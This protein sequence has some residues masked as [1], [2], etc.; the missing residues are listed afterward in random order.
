[1]SRHGD[2]TELPWLVGAHHADR[3][4]DDDAYLPLPGCT[5]LRPY[6]IPMLA[7]THAEIAKAAEDPQQYN[8]IMVRACCA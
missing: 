5:H 4:S 7:C 2:L 6:L 3:L 1:M 8:Q